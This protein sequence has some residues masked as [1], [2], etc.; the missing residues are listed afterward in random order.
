[1]EWE[2]NVGTVSVVEYKTPADCIIPFVYR[3]AD[4]DAFFSGEV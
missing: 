4:W 3:D 1:M 2:D